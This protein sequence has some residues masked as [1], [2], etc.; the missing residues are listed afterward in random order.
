MPRQINL[1]A[2]LLVFVLLISAC[3]STPE[4]NTKPEI[5]VTTSIIADVVRNLTG[6]QIE[7]KSL[8]GPGVDP[9]LYKASQ[10]DVSL[11]QNADL[12][13]YN[14]LHLEGKMSEVLEKLKRSKTV[15]AVSDGLAEADIRTINADAN[16]HDPHIWFD[17][18]IWRK[19]VVY[20]SGE[21]GKSF[22]AMKESIDQNTTQYLHDLDSIHTLCRAEIE[23]LPTEKRILITSHDAFE[24]FGKSFNFHVRGLQGISTLSESGLKDV[25]DMVNFIIDHKIKAVFVENSVPQKALRS[26]ID[27]CKAKGHDVTVGGELFSDALGAA[28][29]PEGTYLGMIQFNV[30]TIVNALK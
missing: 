15:L 9:H 5:V 4:E 19:G 6:D 11:L 29:T 22:P 27:G 14:G 16:V 10:G 13:V 20:I 21:L 26:V 17:M 30:S 12:I 18:T 28:R 23:T 1:P 25:T 7:V 24:Y 2:L 8:M 3:T